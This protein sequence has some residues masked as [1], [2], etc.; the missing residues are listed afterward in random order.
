MLV[1]RRAR[2]RD[3]RPQV[4]TR[5]APSPTRSPESADLGDQA[6]GSLPIEMTAVSG[7]GVA[8]ASTSYEATHPRSHFP[9]TAGAGISQTTTT[10]TSKAE[11]HRQNAC[12][13]ERR[14]F[15]T[16]SVAGRTGPELAGLVVEHL[17]SSR[18]SSRWRRS[19]GITDLAA[20][21]LHGNAS[22]RRADSCGPDAL[23]SR[24]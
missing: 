13:V 6:T 9:A 4:R 17:P 8:S 14:C 21:E 19:P 24:G 7:D 10:V 16:S 2:V 11:R 23:A 22:M 5:R 1:A 20:P 18:P 3:P 15:S 12:R